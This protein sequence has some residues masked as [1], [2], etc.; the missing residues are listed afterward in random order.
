MNLRSLGYECAD[1]RQLKQTK[2]TSDSKTLRRRRACVR[3]VF[4]ARRCAQSL[5]RRSRFEIGPL[6]D[7]CAFPKIISGSPERAVLEQRTNMV[8]RQPVF[9][10]ILEAGQTARSGASLVPGPA[11]IIVASQRY[12]A[13]RPAARWALRLQ[14]RSSWSKSNQGC[15]VSLPPGSCPPSDRRPGHW[16]PLRGPFASVLAATYRPAPASSASVSNTV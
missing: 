10:N 3:L 1:N 11:V 6:G 2:G 16:R 15:L 8:A 7:D 4:R 12:R 13:S 5:G 9:S 14:E